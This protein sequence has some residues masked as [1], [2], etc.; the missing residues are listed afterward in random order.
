MG[1]ESS[2]LPTALGSKVHVVWDVKTRPENPVNRHVILGNC[3]NWGKRVGCRD[4][5]LGPL[6]QSGI[7]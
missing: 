4:V 2:Y 5:N 1:R 6:L 3:R 7:F